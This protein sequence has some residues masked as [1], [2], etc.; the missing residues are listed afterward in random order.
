MTVSSTQLGYIGAKYLGFSYEKDAL[1]E[2]CFTGSNTNLINLFK[3]L[4]PGMLRFGGNT[5]DA[6]T[7]NEYGPGG[8]AGQTAPRDIDSLAAFLRAT[9]WQVIYSVNLARSTAA[10]S[11]AE[12]AYAVKSLGSSLYGV[13][14]GNEPDLFHNHISAYANWTFA[15]FVQQWESFAGAIRAQSPS[16]MLVGP[17]TAGNANTWTIPF[18]QAVG[19]QIGLLSQHYYRGDSLAPTATIQNLISYDARLDSECG[20]LYAAASKNGIPFR[21]TETNSYYNQGPQGIV[22]SYASA[23]WVIDHLFHIAKLGGAGACIHGGSM[24]GYTPIEDNNGQVFMIRPEYYGM[25]FFAMAGSGNVLST[26]LSVGSL[27]VTGYAIRNW[28]GDLSIVVVNKDEYQNVDLTIDCGQQASNAVVTSM[29][30]PSL[31][32][33]TGVA[34]QGAPILVNGTMAV[35]SAYTLAA[36]SHTI[37]CYAPAKSATL[38]QIS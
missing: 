29:T 24:N 11:A 16:V 10:N 13:E 2:P 21:I 4:G 7:W 5:V 3:W 28:K 35:N 20:N 33:T 14:I 8:V 30:G 32:A 12:V 1:Q 19:K 15:D 23:L 31:G 25:R 34:I 17:S 9:G 27:N 26:V 6:I 18:G 37:R 22:D 36:G 38:I